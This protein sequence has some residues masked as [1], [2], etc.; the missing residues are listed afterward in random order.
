M[1][2]ISTPDKVTTIAELRAH[3]ATNHAITTRC[4]PS[5]PWQRVLPGVVL[6]SATRPTRRQRLRAA[7]AYAGP[8][9]VV[10]GV[11]AMRAHGVDVPL[12]PDVLVL[13][14]AERR[15]VSRSYLTVERTTRPP[16][17]TVRAGL[18]YAPLVR[19]ALDVARR[20]ADH[21]QLRALLTSVIGQCTVTELR[22]ELDA[23]SQR[24]SA[25]VRALLTPDLTGAAEVVPEEVTLAR[26]VLRGTALPQPHW[27]QP[28]H[29]D[30]GM[31]LGIPDAWWPEVGLAWDVSPHTRHHDPRVWAAA[32]VALHRTDPQ[33]LSSAPVT[34]TDELVAAFAS[35]A[36]NVHHRAS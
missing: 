8:G 13:A 2:L 11:D 31:L 33:R 4:R 19:A 9:S 12:S 7:I 16:S 29:D 3:G 32:G 25:A 6:M 23:G 26:R 14:P 30:T 1:H 15:L 35:A 22:A 28:V 20:A 18:P 34:V 10:S 5:G 27:Q 36:A 17:P 24:G 21:D